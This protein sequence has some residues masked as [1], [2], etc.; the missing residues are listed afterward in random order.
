MQKVI[1][2]LLLCV[3]A[4]ALGTWRDHS[5]QS[6]SSANEELSPEMVA[7]YLVTFGI[8]ENRLQPRPSCTGGIHKNIAV[9]IN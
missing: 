1:L 3:I 7:F 6:P 4:L 8:A 9:S 2:L 5:I